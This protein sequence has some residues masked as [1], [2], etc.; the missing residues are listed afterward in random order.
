MIEW[1]YRSEKWTSAF[2]K[3]KVK[4]QKVELQ[5]FCINGCAFVN[6]YMKGRGKYFCVQGTE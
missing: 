5:F 4:S 6:C 2:S 1:K 3:A